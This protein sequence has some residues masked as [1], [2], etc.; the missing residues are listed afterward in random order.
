LRDE[1]EK[2]TWWHSIDLGIGIITPGHVPHSTLLRY[3]PLPA[4]LHGKTVLDVGAWDGFYSFEAER[5]GASRVLATDS[6]AWSD[7]IAEGW[8]EQFESGRISQPWLGKP[9]AGFE[10]AR[11]ALNSR[12]EDMNID[13]MDLNPDKVGT[14]D[15]VLFLGVLYHMRHPILA[16]E[17]AASVTKTCLVMETA[18][19]MVWH[20]RPALAFYP[21]SELGD[22]ASN[23][24]GPNP[25]AVKGMLKTVG[26]RK[27]VMVRPR[28]TAVLLA[29][30]LYA[31][32][33]PRDLRQPKTY[34]SKTRLDVLQR[35]RGTFYAW[36]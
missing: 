28:N 32:T 11:R 14:F 4:S 20:R 10:L 13:V 19:D 30:A 27:V 18:M 2:I 22:G 35:G 1:V 16:L 21:G 17:R 25:A 5:R 36:K 23:W 15:V 29:K 6:I 34:F 31:A 33:N 9:K 7:E 26:F 8:T 3:I 24:F 12:V